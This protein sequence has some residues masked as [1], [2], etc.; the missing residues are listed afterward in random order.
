[1]QSAA[2][3][4][5]NGRIG[6]YLGLTTHAPAR[7]PGQRFDIPNGLRAETGYQCKPSPPLGLR[8]SERC[9]LKKFARLRLLC[10]PAKATPGFSSNRKEIDDSPVRRYCSEQKKEF[11]IH[12]AKH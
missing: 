3:N 2:R 11:P 5:N 9:D 6:D 10:R 4:G 7:A 1:M 8:S 12:W